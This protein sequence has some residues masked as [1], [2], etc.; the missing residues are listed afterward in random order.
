MLA[1]VVTV[2]RCCVASIVAAGALVRFPEPAPV[3]APTPPAATFHVVPL[4]GDPLAYDDRCMPFLPEIVRSPNWSLVFARGWSGCLGSGVDDSFA[5]DAE[6]LVRWS[7]PGLPTRTLVLEPDELE[8]LGKLAS[9]DC[10]SDQHGYYVGWYR[11]GVGDD[12]EAKGGAFVAQ[13]SIAGVALDGIFDAAITRYDRLFLAD[14]GP[15]DLRMAIDGGLKLRL[16]DHHLT[17][18]HA[19]K[20]LYRSDLTDRQVTDLVARFFAHPRGDDPDAHGDLYIGGYHL[21]VAVFSWSL[22][23]NDP[24]GY[25][26]RSAH[27][28]VSS[29]DR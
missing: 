14:L 25:A 1:E 16:L 2:R 29:D 6:G 17:I 18:S 9:L 21:D 23:E 19:G 13:E 12:P 3:P 26:I 27:Y 20:L 5:V 22:P 4:L 24:L 7:K 15:A 10:H 8:M 11:I 28:E